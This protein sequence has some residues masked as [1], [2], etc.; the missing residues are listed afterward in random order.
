MNVLIFS[1]TA[2]YGHIAAAQAVSLA[3]TARGAHVVT[4]DLYEHVSPTVQRMDRQWL[5]TGLKIYTADLPYLLPTGRN[6]RPA[7]VPVCADKP[8]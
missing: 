5:H 3:L 2:G 6:P 4:V 7:D 1:V 8:N